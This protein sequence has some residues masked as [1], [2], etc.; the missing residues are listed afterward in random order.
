MN[1]TVYP[2]VYLTFLPLG[3]KRISELTISYRSEAV[4]GEALAVFMAN[5]DDTYYFKTV[6]SDGA[7]NTEAEI[8]LI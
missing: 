7:V 6:K 2:D 3:E 4:M 5:I 8:K 1:N